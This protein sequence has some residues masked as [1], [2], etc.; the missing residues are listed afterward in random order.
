MESKENKEETQERKEIDYSTLKE[1][2]ISYNRAV[3]W[4]MYVVKRV[5]KHRETVDIR[6]RPL[7]AAHV[8][9]VCEALKKL[10]YITYERYITTSVIEKDYLQRL[11]IVTAKR[12]PNFDKLYDARE[13]ERKKMMESK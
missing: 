1:V 10:G 2:N 8:V 5:L 3:N 4:Y 13:E 6:A 7:A 12:T 9:R 11:L